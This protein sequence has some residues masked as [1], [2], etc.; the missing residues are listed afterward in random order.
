MRVPPPLATPQGLALFLDIDGTLAEFQRLPEDVAP[1]LRRTSLLQR[2]AR[3]LKGRVAMISGRAL[4]DVD[5]ITEGVI[6][7]ASGVHG[8]EHRRANG[9]LRVVPPH[10]GVVRARV[11]F[12]AFAAAHPS[13]VLEDKGLGLVLHYRTAPALAELANA[14]AAR[15]AQET[16]LSLQRGDMMAE[17]RTPG[18]DKG[19]ALRAF[20]VEPVFEGCKPIYIG[21]DL[22]DEHAF[23]A[24]RGLGGYG[25]LVGPERTT[26]AQYRL[27]DVEAA[28]VWLEAFATTA[29]HL[30]AS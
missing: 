16:G 2:L 13:M 19:D 12:E 25:V 21:D 18:A 15:V 17:V 1:T 8:L 10:P 4:A 3:V 9:E 27:A 14:T 23:A 28:L 30:T 29:D 24:A 6:T 5:R 22:T 26:A 11:V 7:A 20:M